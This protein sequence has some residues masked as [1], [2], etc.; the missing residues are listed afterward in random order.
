LETNDNKYKFSTKYFFLGCLVG[1]ILFRVALQIMNYEIVPKYRVDRDITNFEGKY[2]H[3]NK[4]GEIENNEMVIIQNGVIIININKKCITFDNYYVNNDTIYATAFLFYTIKFH[5][6]KGRLIVTGNPFSNLITDFFSDSP[7]EIFPKLNL[8]PK[9]E[10][11]IKENYRSQKHYFFYSLE[12]FCTKSCIDDNEIGCESK[13]RCVRRN[14]KSMDKEYLEAVISNFYY[15][16]STSKLFPIG[17]SYKIRRSVRKIFED[18]G[19]DQ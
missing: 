8:F 16:G 6:S 18:C 17:L 5:L 2:L 7:I 13:C 3:L 1:L 15:K 9:Y 11:F 4:D 12:T 19:L 14:I 10:Q